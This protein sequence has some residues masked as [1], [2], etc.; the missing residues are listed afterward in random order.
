MREA[1]LE[2]ER[3][4]SDKTASLWD[5]FQPDINDTRSHAELM[6]GQNESKFRDLIQAFGGRRTSAAELVSESSC[7]LEFQ[8]NRIRY[9]AK[10]NG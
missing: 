5:E 6:Q 1:G 2:S 10:M 3:R 7:L 8:R 4:A 9:A